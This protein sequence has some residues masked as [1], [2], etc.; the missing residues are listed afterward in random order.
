[1]AIHCCYS[2]FLIWCGFPNPSPAEDFT[3][4]MLVTT[5]GISWDR[6]LMII[7]EFIECIFHICCQEAVG[8]VCF[9]W[10]SIHPASQPAHPRANIHRKF[11]LTFKP[12]VHLEA[13]LLLSSIC[14]SCEP[15]EN[16]HRHRDKMPKPLD[17]GWRGFDLGSAEPCTTLIKNKSKGFWSFAWEQTRK[18]MFLSTIS[19][20]CHVNISSVQIWGRLLSHKMPWKSKS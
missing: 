16:P 17:L 14:K 11:T 9:E 19:H 1:M 13:K 3:R 15:G 2:L 6:G 8:W 4:L 7:G 10:N 20:H 12:T 5:I 18:N